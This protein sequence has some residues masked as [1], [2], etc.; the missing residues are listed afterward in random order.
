MYRQAHAFSQLD[1]FHTYDVNNL[2]F[3][4]NCGTHREIKAIYKY[5][6]KS[7]L[8]AKIFLALIKL[9]IKDMVKGG[10]TFHLPTK[11]IAMFTWKKMQDDRFKR[12]YTGGNFPNL[13]FIQANFTIFTPIM[14]FYYRKQFVEK[15]MI[16]SSDLK[17]E[18]IEKTNN[19]FKYC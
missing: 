9:I 11:T 6:S 15:D 19:G 8:V 3:K 4:E 13:D 18:I 12:A 10:H 7:N 14:K 2:K 17:G 16:P 1:L 5:E